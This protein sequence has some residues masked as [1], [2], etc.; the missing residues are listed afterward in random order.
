MKSDCLDPVTIQAF[1]DGELPVLEMESAA[2]H[3]A[4]CPAC[5]EL[6]RELEAEIFAIGQA[7]EPELTL[8]VP[9]AQLRARVNAAIDELAVNERSQVG[10][11][12]FG[13]R[14]RTWISSLTPQMAFGAAA[15][16]LVIGIAGWLAIS[17]MR[18]QRPDAGAIV[19][20]LNLTDGSALPDWNMPEAPAPVIPEHVDSTVRHTY[21]PPVNRLKEN[22]APAPLPGESTYQDTIAQLDHSLS[23]RNDIDLKPTMRADMEKNLALLDQAILSSQEQ[24]RRNPKDPN[25]VA[26]LNTAYQNKIEFLRTVSDQAQLYAT[27][28]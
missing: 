23:E 26:F 9:T 1:L 10:S 13:E 20:V 22:L 7:F 14:L 11:Q 15:A 27:L 25:A 18:A 4:S 16:V 6:T 2:A 24:A 12:T 19:A 3:T 8:P 21:L 5:N 17:V 28:R